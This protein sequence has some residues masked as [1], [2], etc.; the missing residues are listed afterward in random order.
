MGVLGPVS[1]TGL[2][3]AG[4]R[5]EAYRFFSGIFPETPEVDRIRVLFIIHG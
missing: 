5:R 1:L 4:K 2:L 3:F